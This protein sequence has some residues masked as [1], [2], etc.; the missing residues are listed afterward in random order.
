MINSSKQILLIMETS[1]EENASLAE[2]DSS[3]VSITER[4]EISCLTASFSSCTTCMCV[5]R[6]EK[7]EREVLSETFTAYDL[8]ANGVYFDN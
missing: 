3:L 5:L 2:R 7:G 4:E 6:R 8:Q 1:K